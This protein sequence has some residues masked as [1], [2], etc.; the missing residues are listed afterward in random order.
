M[1]DKITFEILSIR[2][3]DP[4]KLDDTKYVFYIENLQRTI[5][6]TKLSVFASCQHLLSNQ[7]VGELQRLHFTLLIGIHA[8]Q[9]LE[10]DLHTAHGI[11][12]LA[13]ALQQI[14]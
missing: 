2:S 11:D 12:A 7:I 1:P 8:K 14:L 9:C 6:C 10:N 13:A 4:L 3:F 5:S